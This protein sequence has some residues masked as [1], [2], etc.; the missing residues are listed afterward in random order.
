LTENDIP[1]SVKFKEDT[2]FILN[3]N[4]FNYR[5]ISIE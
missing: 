4:K 3:S 2:I 5:L 1:A